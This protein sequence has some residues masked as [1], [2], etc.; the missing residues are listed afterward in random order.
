MDGGC[1]GKVRLWKLPLNFG[2]EINIQNKNPAPYRKV[3]LIADYFKEHKI[4]GK[5]LILDENNN[6]TIKE[7]D[8]H[9]AFDELY[10]DFIHWESN[11]KIESIDLD[12]K[13]KSFA[14]A[15]PVI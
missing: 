7:Q 10:K 14:F 15:T 11:A 13:T 6:I 8:F 5:V 4:K 2:S 9:T 12:K 3:C 1:F